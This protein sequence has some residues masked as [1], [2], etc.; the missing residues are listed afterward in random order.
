MKITFD[1]ESMTLGEVEEFEEISGEDI[2]QIG[3]GALSVKSMIA[4]V[5]IDQRRTNPSTR[6]MTPAR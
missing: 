1:V 4:L 6:W 5:Y 3:S 2:T